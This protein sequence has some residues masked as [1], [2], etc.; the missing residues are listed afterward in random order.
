MIHVIGGTPVPALAELRQKFP[1]V[2]S[3][4]ACR[5]LEPQVDRSG[6]SGRSDVPWEKKARLHTFPRRAGALDRERTPYAGRKRSGRMA[7]MGERAKS[8]VLRVTI[9]EQPA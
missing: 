1:R 8:S 2:A 3:F 7:G 6:L 9:I 5:L 4:P